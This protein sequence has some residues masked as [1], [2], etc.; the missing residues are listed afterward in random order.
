MMRSVDGTIPGHLCPVYGPRRAGSASV[1]ETFGVSVSEGCYFL[2]CESF[3]FRFL[4][5]RQMDS[6]LIAYDRTSKYNASFP[7]Q[8][9]CK[10]GGRRAESIATAR[11]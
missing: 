11:W 8:V 3:F 4:W 10:A 9:S 5:I 1:S 2:A 6:L 7:F